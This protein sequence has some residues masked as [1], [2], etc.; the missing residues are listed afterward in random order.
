MDP[1]ALLFDAN[2]VANIAPLVLTAIV[3]ASVALLVGMVLGRKRAL[4]EDLFSGDLFGKPSASAMSTSF[5][6]IALGAPR[7]ITKLSFTQRSDE[8]T[9]I[10]DEL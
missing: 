4:N 3:S 7:S 9:P 5:S 1:T 2:P 6:Q 8:Y 10:P